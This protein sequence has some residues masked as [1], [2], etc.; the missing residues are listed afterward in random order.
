M[1][2][3]GEWLKQEGR[4]QR[5]VAQRMGVHP[6]AVNRWVAGTRRPNSHQAL[7]LEELTS[8]MVPVTSWDASPIVQL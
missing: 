1:T 6:S 3:L 4:L 7:A 8:G 5:W 2:Q